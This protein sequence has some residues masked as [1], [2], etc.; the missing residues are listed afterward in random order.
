MRAD[1][2]L[3][4]DA[5]LVH[6]LCYRSRALIKGPVNDPASAVCRLASHAAEKNARLGITGALLFDNGWFAQTL[7]G[8][9]ETV[10]G[11]FADIAR[12]SR[13][14]EV[15]LAW[16]MGREARAFPEWSMWLLDVLLPDL[17]WL[18]D[19]SAPGH[20]LPARAVHDLR[21]MRL[22]VSVPA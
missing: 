5:G 19:G 16:E 10:R 2:A 7:E 14:A 20:G 3:E 4:P 8:E 12:D 13:H 6:V 17:R 15:T 21:S 22:L 11:L 18:G 1:T 9:C